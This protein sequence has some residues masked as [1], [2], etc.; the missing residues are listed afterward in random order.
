[1]RLF[2]THCHLDFKAY[3]DDRPA[4]LARAR[5]AGVLRFLIP[6]VDY[7][8]IARSLA[9]ATAEADIEVAVGLHPNSTAAWNAAQDL[10][11][12]RALVGQGGERVRAIGEIG[13]D[14]HWDKSPKATQW[15][16]LEDQLGL[17]AELGLPVIIHNRE[18]DSDCLPILEAWAAS[19]SGPLKNRPGVFHSCSLPRPLAARAVAAGF[20]LGFSGPLTY[21][22]AEEMRAVAAQT[23]LDR[24]L[25]ETDAPFLTPTP[26]RGE[27]NEPAYVAL[28]LERLASLHRLPA[29]EM[30][31]QTS[32]NGARLFGF[33]FV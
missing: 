12:L 28:V 20:Y 7:E 22:N 15:R 16:A 25:I 13:L 19:L 27:R 11:K 18:A 31:R 3:H 5:A 26:H 29:E 24:L 9:L 14:Y 33:N 8:S 4:M 32:D 1:M 21:K 6:G 30:A 17:A 10:P 23:P 2:D